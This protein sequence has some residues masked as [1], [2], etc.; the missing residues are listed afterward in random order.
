MMRSPKTLFF[1]SARSPETMS[2][3]SPGSIVSGT[4]QRWLARP[5]LSVVAVPS[6]TGSENTAALIREPGANPVAV[7]AMES[8]C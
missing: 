2:V 7:S 1:T 8:P 3:W 6:T 4:A 5:L